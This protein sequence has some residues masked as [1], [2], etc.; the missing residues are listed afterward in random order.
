MNITVK[1]YSFVSPYSDMEALKMLKMLPQNDFTFSLLRQSLERPLS[2]LQL[3]WVHKLVHDAE[4]PKEVWV[5]IAALMQVAYESGIKRPRFRTELVHITRYHDGIVVRDAQ[6][7]VKARLTLQGMVTWERLSQ[8]L[9]DH[10]RFIDKAPLEAARVYGQRTGNCS[11]CSK[12]LT[13]RV[14]RWLNYG[15]IC[16]EKWGL[17]HDYDP[18]LVPEDF[19]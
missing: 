11:F 19:E 1:G 12:C 6:R 5:R 13:N 16:A 4:K 9:L 2:R 7:V 18:D 8:E 17:P 10:L 14:S 3:D 15:P